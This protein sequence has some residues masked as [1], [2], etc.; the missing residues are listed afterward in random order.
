MLPAE[1]QHQLGR[2]TVPPRAL[3]IYIFTMIKA[4]FVLLA[5]GPTRET[6]LHIP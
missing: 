5:D 2:T 4:P 1:E 3:S 6:L